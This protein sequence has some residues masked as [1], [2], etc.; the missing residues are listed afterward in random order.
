MLIV[1]FTNTAAGEMRDRIRERL[2]EQAEA[3]ED[4]G[5]QEHLRVR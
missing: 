2:E 3:E 5:M 4:P 1:T